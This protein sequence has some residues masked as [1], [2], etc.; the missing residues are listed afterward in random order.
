MSTSEGPSN[1]STYLLPLQSNHSNTNFGES[2]FLPSEIDSMKHVSTDLVGAQ[3]ICA[4]TP[5]DDNTNMGAIAQ[6]P[7]FRPITR[8]DIMTLVNVVARNLGLRPSSV[9]VLDALLSCLPCSDPKTR[10]DRPITP[11]TLLTVYAANETLCFRAR[12]ITDRQL[13]RHFQALE[14]AGLIRRRDSA[15]GKRFPVRRGG[16]VIGAFGI[17][18][19]P[20]FAR[21]AELANRAATLR[22]QEA[23]RRGLKARIQALRA[24]LSECAM[25]PDDLREVIDGLGKVLR[26]TSVSLHELRELLDRLGNAF[27]RM[28]KIKNQPT[29]ADQ[30]T[31]TDGRNVRHK[32]PEKTDSQKNDATR[33]RTWRELST[34]SEFYPT[35]PKTEH[36]LIAIARQF[37]KMLGIGEKALL[38]VTEKIGWWHCLCLLDEIALKITD[39]RSP[40]AYFRSLAARGPSLRC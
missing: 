1:L 38:H 7:T 8:R 24:H 26:R 10:T 22:A 36:E 40:D 11:L 25:L 18:L 13:R 20:L 4:P 16:Q 14:T 28:S 6:Q 19:S 33:A 32:E 34:V 31:A 15:N 5:F 29:T 2:F 17:D 30:M 21:A 3:V 39:V 9:V 27:K 12:G 23:E 37:S 35:S